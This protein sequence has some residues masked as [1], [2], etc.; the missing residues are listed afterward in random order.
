MPPKVNKVEV[1]LRKLTKID[2]NKTCANCPEKMP[3]YA[4]M[5]HCIFVCT[6]C[7]GIHRDFQFKVKGISMSTFTEEDVVNLKNVGNILHNAV[8]MAKHRSD[9]TLPNG[10]DI[11][12]LKEFIKMK[13]VDRKWYDGD[14]GT[15]SH[16]AGDAAGKLAASPP[17]NGS[18]PP[19]RNSIGGL[20]I[21][22]QSFQQAPA[23]A[24]AAQKPSAT[25]G[26]DL[27]SLDSSQ[28]TSATTSTTSSTRSN[29]F[30]HQSPTQQSFSA[31]A[32]AAAAQKPSNA[33]G[34]DLLSLDSHQTSKPSSAASNGSM[35]DPFSAPTPSSGEAA[36]DPFASS[37]A[38]SDAFDPFGPSTGGGQSDPFAPQATP[39]RTAVS[40]S[41]FSPFPNNGFNPQ[42]QFDAFNQPQQQQQQ[43]QQF[44]SF[45]NSPMPA[46]QQTAP[47]PFIKVAPP[48]KPVEAA[49]QDP[50]DD[51]KTIAA[52]ATT[53]A[54][55]AGGPKNFSFFD[56]L[57]EPET[58][59]PFGNATNF[60]PP[61][62]TGGP[63]GGNPFSPSQGQ[64]AGYPA[65]GQ[66]QP[67]GYAQGQ[68]HAQ[69]AQHG[70]F[71]QPQGYSPQGPGGYAPQG[72]GQQPAQAYGGFQQYPPQQQQQHPGYPPQ[73]PYGAP[74]QQMYP[75]QPGPP[76]QQQGYPPQQQQ[77]YGQC[78]PNARAPGQGAPPHQPKVEAP[79]APPA[80]P[81]PFESMTN[82]L[83]WDALGGKPAPRPMPKTVSAPSPVL[84]TDSGDR[85]PFDGGGD[86]FGAAPSIPAPAVPA[87]ASANP[88]DFF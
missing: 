80:A 73:M 28:T 41:G 58:D 60:L 65:H 3:G 15:G 1:E 26:L 9:Q 52:A 14:I 69:H 85:N 44:S 23:P 48:P 57:V 2:G 47:L 32:P 36:F 78:A 74:Q 18:K 64:P 30:N 8:Y 86:F 77:G 84:S 22:A 21:N 5:T 27:L 56:D 71:A 59:N 39:P 40:S 10:S 11:A 66:Q 54:P 83:G 16:D 82:S 51:A 53:G 19:T 7:A 17:S 68:G 79:P 29:G 55:K 87:A 72:Y 81:D 20:T 43:Q 37:S 46:Y 24:A 35:F 4:E 42:Q 12:K 75:P 76:Y 63:S 62:A 38:Q 31:P 6:K 50:K 25:F 33:F 61:Q 34:L 67:S 45:G 13:Y 70:Q 88:F 49:I